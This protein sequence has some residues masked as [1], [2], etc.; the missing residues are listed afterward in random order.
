[1][2]K[3]LWILA[4]LVFVPRAKADTFVA[5]SGFVSLS[6]DGGVITLSGVAPSGAAFTATGGMG[7]QC[8]TSFNSGDPIYPCGYIFD[9]NGGDTYLGILTVTVN[10]ASSK[11]YIGPFESYP[12]PFDA[13]LMYLSGATQATLS[14]PAGTEFIACGP[15][16]QPIAACVTGGPIPQPT[17]TFVLDG[18]PWEYTVNLVADSTGYLPPVNSFLPPR[19]SRVPT[20]FFCPEWDCCSD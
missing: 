16:D 8:Q 6:G 14:E 1:M 15:Q 5:T 3:I 18:P 17:T 20:F 12:L 19:P 11:Y 2:R 9:G 7:I 13:V 4:F 10:K